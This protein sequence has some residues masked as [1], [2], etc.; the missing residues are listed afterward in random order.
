MGAY[1]H[2]EDS[3]KQV[4]HCPMI[5]DA[6]RLQQVFW[7]LLSNAIKFT[8]RGGEVLT[9]IDVVD[10][11]A[12]ITVR[13]TGIGI[14]AD[15]LPEIFEA[16]RQEDNSITRTR[17]GLGLG[18]SIVKRI[19]ELHGGTAEAT[20][21]GSNAGATFTLRIPALA[22]E[23][24]LSFGARLRVAQKVPLALSLA[25][26]RVLAV[27]DDP[28]IRRLLRAILDRAGATSRIVSS[29]DQAL[30]A[31]DFA[32]G[33]L[34]SDLAMPYRDGFAL[35]R[36]IREWD[37]RRGLRFTP[38]IALTGLARSEDRTHA[39]TAGYDLY[40]TK[41]FQP[42]ELI[43]KIRSLIDATVNSTDCT[44]ACDH[45]DPFSRKLSFS[46]SSGRRT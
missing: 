41:P 16:F 14:S 40:I 33:V 25:G 37:F 21:A 15:S 45:P 7:N 5:G 38:S 44:F 24:A 34:I 2:N 19:V 30:D 1:S 43:S 26:I 29:V 28:E 32:P 23:T 6:D 35:I 18:L 17:S 42:L 4:E 10:S 46:N 12:K 27:D 39:L 36:K 20:S 31:L 9:E 13:D 22:R 3:G 8:P 11:F